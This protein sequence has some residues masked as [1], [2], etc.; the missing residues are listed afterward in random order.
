MIATISPNISNGEHSLNTLRYAD[1]YFYFNERVKELKGDSG[2]EH[3]EQEPETYTAEF[4]D[5]ISDHE[6]EEPFLI[7]SEFPP[8]TMSLIDDMKLISPGPVDDREKGSKISILEKLNVKKSISKESIK[9]ECLSKESLKDIES[10]DDLKGMAGA[11]AISD[12]AEIVQYMDDLIK[13][14]R[15]HLRMTT[16][17][18]KNE[19]K[20][21]VNF[22]M[23]RTTSDRVNVTAADYVKQVEHY[24]DLKLENL[25]EIK[26]KI[27]QIRLI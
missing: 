20:L 24:I 17:S 1:R 2:I 15:Q 12:E 19:S 10:I 25:N 22:T 8:D 23:K 3:D 13:L 5:D 16:D 9:V 26:R 4:E 27:Q 21:L 14:H 11:E 18:G 7:D 6:V